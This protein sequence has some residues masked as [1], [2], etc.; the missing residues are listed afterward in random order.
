MNDTEAHSPA[1]GVATAPSTDGEA[2]AARAA[3]ER[4]SRWLSVGPTS[5][6]A[7]IA[8]L[9][10]LLPVGWSGLWAPHELEVAGVQ[11]P[12]RRHERDA[13]ALGSGSGDEGAGVVD[14][15]QG[16]DRHAL[17]TVLGLVEA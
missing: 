8:L 12:H 14:G 9:S 1:L 6:A 17:S 10:I 15:G 11:R 13:L 4:R 3:G 7:L 2:V 16:L 5:V